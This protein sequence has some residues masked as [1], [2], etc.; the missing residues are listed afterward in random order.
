LGDVGGEGFNCGECG[1]GL[2]EM[3]NRCVAERFDIDGLV[4]TETAAGQEE[5]A[6]CDGHDVFILRIIE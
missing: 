6:I 4:E 2:E 1:M 3:W 5:D